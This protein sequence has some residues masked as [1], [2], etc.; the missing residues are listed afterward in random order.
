MIVDLLRN[1][2]SKVCE[3]HSVTVPHL[4]ELQSFSTVHHLVSSIQGQ[5]LQN[6]EPL[7][8]LRACFPGGSITGAPKRRAMQIIQELE[9]HGRSVYCGSFFYLGRND[10]LD[11]NIAIRTLVR[12]RNTL[13]CWGGGGITIGSRA[14]A[15]YQESL[16]K[17]AR[18]TNYHE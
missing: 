15:E 8:L 16:D 2:L 17:I 18:L 14:D 5:L 11:A 10:Q 13:Y 4:F 3:P 1:D 9:S 12:H 7:D 6:R